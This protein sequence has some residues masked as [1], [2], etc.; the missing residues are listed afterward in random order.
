MRPKVLAY[1]EKHAPEYLTLPDGWPVQ[2]HRVGTWECYRQ[3]IRPENPDYEW[4]EPRSDDIPAP[5]TGSGARV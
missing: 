2:N 3:D 1:I 4:K 5:P